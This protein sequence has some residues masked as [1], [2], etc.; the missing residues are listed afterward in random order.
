MPTPRLRIFLNADERLREQM[1]NH[2]RGRTTNLLLV[3]L[4][5]A[6]VSQ[7]AALS[8]SAETM[9]RAGPNPGLY[10]EPARSYIKPGQQ[11]TLSVMVDNSV[12]SLSCVFCTITYDPQVVDCITAEEGELYLNSSYSTF[13]N[14]E[15]LSPDSVRVEDCVLGY[16]SFFLTPGELFTI[17]FEG[18]QTGVSPVQIEEAEVYDI[19]RNEL[20]AEIGSGAD[21]SVSI[22]ADDESSI[23]KPASFNC[24][25]NPFNPSATLSFYPRGRE[26]GKCPLKGEL[27]IYSPSGGRIRTL[28]RGTLN[29]GRNEFYWDGR[30]ERGREVSSGVYIAVLKTPLSI[31]RE[32]MILVR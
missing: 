16:R 8:V 9:V 23:P 11:C 1:Y 27:R 24:Y 6:V 13:F 5:L 30:N 3:M 20:P 28:F 18:I 12:D 17:V 10:L 25:P 14:W 2:K 29:N 4:I 31:Y 15:L 26:H 32:K 19:D 7:A 21:I 22:T